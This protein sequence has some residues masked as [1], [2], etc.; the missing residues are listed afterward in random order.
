MRTV[1]CAPRIAEPVTL[2]A[3]DRWFVALD[4]CRIGAGDDSSETEVLGI[5]SDGETFWVQLAPVGS[6]CT[7]FILHVSL[8]L[9]VDHVRT[10]LAARSTH[11]ESCPEIIEVLH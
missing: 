5:H 3:A 2:T 6:P 1:G 4:H 11:Q 10:A 9:T 8:A 7:A